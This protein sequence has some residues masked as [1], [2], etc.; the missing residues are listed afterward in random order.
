MAFPCPHYHGKLLHDNNSNTIV[1]QTNK[2]EIT[3]MFHVNL[4]YIIAFVNVCYIAMYV[5]AL[6]FIF[7]LCVF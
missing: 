6:T 4:F 1:S 3:A 7:K 5:F 2:R